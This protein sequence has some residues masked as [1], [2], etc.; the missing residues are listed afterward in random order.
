MT[1]RLRDRRP[2][3]S[4]RRDAPA[5]SRAAQRDVVIFLGIF[6]VVLLINALLA[7]ALFAFLDAAGLLGSSSWSESMEG[8]ARSRRLPGT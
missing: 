5:V 4:A 1:P 2:V 6:G 8:L 3:M 7:I